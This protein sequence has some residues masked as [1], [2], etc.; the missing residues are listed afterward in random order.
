M[1]IFSLFGK[2]SN[3][4]F[5]GC[6]TYFK[7]PDIFELYKKIFTK[8]GI[9]FK[10]SDKQICCGLPALEAGYEQTARKLVRRNFEIFKEQ[11]IKSIITNSPEAYKMFLE[12]SPDM[13]P[14]WDIGV[15]NL[16]EIILD[17]L[18][19]KSRLI[20][21]K[22]LE[23]VTYH[24]SCYLGR[25]C[26]IYDEPRRILELIGYEIREM[27]DSKSEAICCGSCGGLPRTN[28]GLADEVA[29]QR[30]LQA[31]RIGVKK[32]IVASVE[33]YDLL[34]KNSKDS[35][36]EILELSQVLAIALGIKK[37]EP[38][39]VEEEISGEEQIILDVE[40]NERIREELKD[41]ED[42]E[43]EDWEK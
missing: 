15:R 41:E 8:L 2:S 23:I 25:Y 17:K 42:E 28:S 39:I 3:L 37:K 43:V 11:R 32:I 26:D 40:A 12:E 13:L 14:D 9:G 18:K 1:G 33:N 29:K 10:I 7:Y 6:M 34:K 19:S 24:D 27:S 20:K 5:P 36:I 21:N 4:Y 30:I 38:E 22:A 16:W 35:D 31:K